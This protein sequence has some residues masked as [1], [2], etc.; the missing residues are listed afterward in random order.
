MKDFKNKVAVITGAASGIGRGLA[1]T[2]AAAGMRVVL[3]DF[4]EPTLAETTRVLSATGADVHAVPADVTKPDQV[5]ELARQTLAKY[6]AVHVLCNNAGSFVG[7]ESSWTRP[8]S[9]W[10]WILG[11]NVMGV[12]HGI[13]SFLPIMIEQGTEAHIVN[14]ASL[15]GLLSAGSVL[16]GTAKY[17]VVGLTE[18]LHAE[19]QRAGLKP[20]VSVL[21]PGLVDTNILVNSHRDRPAESADA[22][23]PPTAADA[24]RLAEARSVVVAALKQSLNPRAVGQEVLAAIRHERFYILVN[25]EVNSYLEQRA[26]NMMKD[27]RRVG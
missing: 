23:P 6:G 16:Y 3:S 4:D 15:G 25:P 27:N 20:K 17:A 1:E 5:S 14:T 11:V 24:A 2:F 9:D 12:V 19:L 22:G 8:L 13:R 7:G 21:C 10:E 18:N 26:K